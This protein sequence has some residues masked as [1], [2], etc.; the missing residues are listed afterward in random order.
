MQLDLFEDNRPGILLNI[1]DEFIRSRD[2]VQAVS[3]YE[4]LLADYPNDRHPAALLK[5]VGE[6]LDLISR[7]DEDPGNPSPLLTIWLG[8]E[9]ICHPALHSAV[10]G[11]LIDK[12]RSLPNPELIYTPPRFH[13]GHA[14]IKAGQYAA[15][16]DCFHDALL[17]GGIERGKFL[18]W[19]GDALTLA[20]DSK[21]ALK[22][23]LTAFLD[24]PLTV[25][26]QSVANRKISDLYA[27][28]HYETTDEIE[29]DEIS[30]WLPVWGWLH[31]VFPLPM[32]A[33][34]EKPSF[35]LEEFEEIIS[36]MS[37][38]VPRI[39]Y[40]MLTYAERMRNMHQDE[41]ASVRRL[42]KKTNGFM[43]GCYMEK[44]SGRR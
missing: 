28:M 39:W 38:P 6:W 32:H 43:F 26:M 30:A 18:A 19:Q 10:L 25:D 35:S 7:A 12:L 9:S 41:L 31:G 8:L 15:A 36:K 29:D 23:Y 14:L 44:I 17:A 37:S 16:A 34:A 2:F 33:V 4:Q 21:A 11:L 1:A 20:G 22:S 27:S 42:M 13:L 40:D 3:V 5:L 24:D